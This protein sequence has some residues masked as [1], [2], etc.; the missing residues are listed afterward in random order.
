MTIK[1]TMTRKMMKGMII[2]MKTTAECKCY[3]SNHKHFFLE[4]GYHNIILILISV[5]RSV[6]LSLNLLLKFM[7]P[8]LI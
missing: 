2:I 7:S 3:F 4:R 5:Y 8:I 1:M 6:S